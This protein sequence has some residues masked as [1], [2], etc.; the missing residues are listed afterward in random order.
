[1]VNLSGENK[2]IIFIIV[3]IIGLFI[4]AY[5][6]SFRNIGC[7]NKDENNTYE[8][9]E[10]EKKESV[11]N[12]E[13][14]NNILGNNVEQGHDIKGAQYNYNNSITQV[15][16]PTS[17][18]Y[19]ISIP[20]GIKNT[21]TIPVQL[22]EG[23]SYEINCWVCGDN[24]TTNDG[25]LNGVIDLS[26]KN[27]NNS[28]SC[29]NF[30]HNSSPESR[31]VN[32]KKWF[33]KI[34]LFNTP[35]HLSGSVNIHLGYSN[36]KR[37]IAGLTL[38]KVVNNMKGFKETSGL[39]SSFIFNKNNVLGND[40]KDNVKSNNVLSTNSSL[41][42]GN[43]DGVN[44]LSKT[45]SGIINPNEYKKSDSNNIDVF[46]FVIYCD[47][48][49]IDE[50]ASILHID[51]NQNTSLHLTLN[52]GTVDAE[53][54]EDQSKMG[55]FTMLHGDD[56][57]RYDSKPH[58]LIGK[59]IYFFTCTGNSIKCYLNE[60]ESPFWSFDTSSK[61]YF[62]H[63]LTI[64][65]GG[66][67]NA[68][69]KALL[70]YNRVL[71]IQTRTNIIN[72]LKY[73]LPNEDK[74][75]MDQYTFNSC[76]PLGPSTDHNKFGLETSTYGPNSNS[77]IEIDLDN[78]I[79]G[80]NGSKKFLD[81]TENGVKV[82]NTYSPK[83]DLE[84][85]VD[86]EGADSGGSTPQSI[87][88]HIDPSIASNTCLDT[89]IQSCSMNTQK[90]DTYDVMSCLNKCKTDIPQCKTLCSSTDS[91][92]P[93]ICNDINLDNIKVTNSCPNVYQQNGDYY[94]HVPKTSFYGHVYGN[95]N[96][97]KNYGPSK[98][99]AREVYQKNYP[100]CEI[101]DSLKDQANYNP[102]HCPYTIDE[103]NPCTSSNC[104]N[105]E[106]GKDSYSP[107]EI[108][109]ECKNDIINYCKNN[110]NL[111]PNCA[112]WK[113]ENKNDPASQKH[114][115]QFEDQCDDDCT[116]GRHPIES[117]PDY[118]DYI[119]KDNIPCWNCDLK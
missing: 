69:I 103:R 32:G 9:Y 46:T 93:F 25:K 101:P 16:N 86:L 108:T 10:N 26:T 13:Q 61:L 114:R 41:R 27:K 42:F 62:N 104:R 15:K 4:S 90:N 100:K 96:L 3:V 53:D 88:T 72:Y 80:Y 35:L 45:L 7:A 44:I 113:P 118:K 78:V 55:Y 38:N 5:F 37:D 68:N 50:E 33:K 73:T 21:Y 36:S 85:T 79:G 17:S 116:P 18:K 49:S 6:L 76:L 11:N 111:D 106:W 58:F 75:K 39:I 14:T 57:S 82:D 23:T 19:V 40:I 34:I 67:W 65:K 102:N 70:L 71:D 112:S 20:N 98:D 74:S 22:K 2:R 84:L 99:N 66:K 60:T 24:L 97:T 31:T 89:C 92:K 51:G 81:V 56:T 94:V 43:E 117:H 83:D 64:N 12:N 63:N 87:P 47:T 95:T 59:N 109:P 119:K 29:I 54:E 28:N 8:N 77:D 107:S 48:I 30:R 105:V 91:N 52:K 115:R 110:H 1:M